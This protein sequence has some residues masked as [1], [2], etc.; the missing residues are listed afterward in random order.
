MLG[1]R[2]RASDLSA[3]L[4]DSVL[5]RHGRRRREAGAGKRIAFGSGAPG[6]CS[7]SSSSFSEGSE[8][9]SYVRRGHIGEGGWTG[10][11]APGKSSDPESLK[12]S[13]LAIRFLMPPV[14]RDL[15]M[16]MCR[17]AV[18]TLP[19]W[20]YGKTFRGLCPKKTK[21][22]DRRL[23]LTNDLRRYSTTHRRNRLN[24]S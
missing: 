9:W 12:S 21:W 1:R 11:K 6:E 16:Q 23:G 20:I 8:W 17:D 24:S 7:G 19:P 22:H 5:L 13:R 2:V 15:F 18:R 10:S 3:T 14:P 4:V